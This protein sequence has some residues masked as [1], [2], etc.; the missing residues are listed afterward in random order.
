MSTLARRSRAGTP[1]R[2]AATTATLLWVCRRAGP[3]P[4]VCSLPRTS[5]RVSTRRGMW[6]TDIA[7][8]RLGPSGRVALGDAIE[9]VPPL[10]CPPSCQ[11]STPTGAA[12]P[13]P[14][15][16]RAGIAI[17]YSAPARVRP[18]SASPHLR[19]GAVA[20]LL[21]ARRSGDVKRNARPMPISSRHKIGTEAFRRLRRLPR[22]VAG[23]RRD[24]ACAERG[25]Q[26]APPRPHR[27]GRDLTSEY[28]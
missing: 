9:T 25:V 16:R 24:P 19:A 15:P 8:E 1:G 26:D 20:Q 22:P 12:E 17:R 18:R 10:R 11:G 6:T 5:R 21:A 13:R 4:G 27:R 3:G 2:K 28:R 23:R 14:K 7:S